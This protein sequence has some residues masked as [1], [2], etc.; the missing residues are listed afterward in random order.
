VARTVFFHIGLPKTGTTYLQTVMWN[1]RELLR[2]AGLLLPGVERRDH[3]WSSLVVR[4]DD[5]VA[6]RNELATSSW[7]RVRHEIANWSGDAI[8]SH[9]FFAAATAEQAQLAIDMLAPAEVHVVTTARD[10][11]G[12]FTAS[13][14]ELVKNKG[15]T[16]LAEYS[17]EESPDPVEVWNWRTLDLGLVLERWTRSVPAER[18]HVVTTPKPDAPRQLLWHRF[19]SVIGAD[20]DGLDLS[21]SFENTSM[22]VVETEV[23]RRVNGFLED[24]DSPLD[25]GVWIRTFLADERLVPRQGEK[26]WPEPDQVDDC[27][28]RGAAAVALVRDRGFRVVGDIEDLLVPDALPERRHPDSVTDAEV[29]DVAVQTVAVLLGDVRRI[30]R[31]RRAAREAAERARA[32]LQARNAPGL[33]RRLL[34]RARR[35]WSRS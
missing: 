17:R 33:T 35:M 11:L 6:K 9:E 13:W 5:S 32:E 34:R 4:G 21:A 12:I 2:D 31:E 7:E 30:S 28:N 14:Q 8:I 15:T 19:A 1:N 26:Y 27:R 29:A 10:P 16:P 24:F 25:R 20:S 18:V 22:G 3:L 23:L